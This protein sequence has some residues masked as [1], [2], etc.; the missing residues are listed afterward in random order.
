META[1]TQTRVDYDT[2]ELRTGRLHK[3]RLCEGRVLGE[4]DAMVRVVKCYCRTQDVLTAAEVESQRRPTF[5]FPE[6]YFG[7]LEALIGR[8]LEGRVYFD[9]ERRRVK[10]S[11]DLREHAGFQP[12]EELR[13]LNSPW[14]DDNVLKE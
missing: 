4:Q 9:T 1:A 13:D 14:Y 2:V 11:L 12:E 3:I 5:V 6:S 10:F 8:E 7:G